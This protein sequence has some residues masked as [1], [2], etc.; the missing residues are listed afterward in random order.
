VGVDFRHLRLESRPEIA[1]GAIRPHES[2]F[3]VTAERLVSLD[4]FRGLTVAAMVIVNNPGT[5]SAMYWP[6]EH[7]TWNGWT[8]TDLIFPFFL[9]IVG[10]SLTRSRQT[11]EAPVWRLVRRALVLL[12]LGLLLT[13]FPR[14]DPQHWRFTG[15]LP[16]IAFCYL[17]AAL[18]YRASAVRARA[19]RTQVVAI[20]GITIAILLGYW[21]MLTG[22]GD[23][24]P[25]GNIGAAIDRQLFGSHL[26][27]SGRWDPEGLL[28][29]VPAVATTLLGLLAGLWIGAAVPLDRKI[30]ALAGGGVAMMIAGQL[31]DVW[32]PINKNLWTSSYVVLTGGAAAIA[33]AACLYAIDC[34]GWRRWSQPFVAFGMNAI[35]LF[36]VS[37]LIG[38][39]LVV[40]SLQGPIY[41][42]GFAWMASP[43]TASLLYSLAFLAV[44]YAMC[45][46]LY[47]HRVFLKA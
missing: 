2:A 35:A 43:K 40:W 16:R 27:R 26:Y 23:L 20:A 38:K 28:S 15:I 41:E 30:R 12:A 32:L 44:M 13:G 9:F 39:A 10:V 42:Y 45:D 47:R 17:V 14:F 33:L 19:T 31:W 25:E 34:R 6:L 21:L 46:W 22:M 18:I 36:V 1:V 37:G 11:R 24:T 29:S 3:P 8:P 7:A 4:V 5:W